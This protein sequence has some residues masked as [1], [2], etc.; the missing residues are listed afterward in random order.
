MS[1]QIYYIIRDLEKEAR[2]IDV[3]IDMAI[4]R[5]VGISPRNLT[6]SG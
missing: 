1:K 6:S 2:R 4:I 3:A 5:C